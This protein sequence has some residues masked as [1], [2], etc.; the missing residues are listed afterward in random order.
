MDNDDRQIG[1]ILSRREV[2][3]VLGVAGAGLLAGCGT[4]QPASTAQLASATAQPAASTPNAEAQTAAALGNN[5]TAVASASAKAATAVAA[6]ATVAA[7]NGTAV[8]SCVVRPEVTEGPYYVAEDLVRSDIR[9]DP[10]TGAVKAGTP[11][12]LTFNVSR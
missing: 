4:A 10:G 2:L 7:A 9:S 8:P 5:P 3:K 6:N 12:A 11:L 1:R